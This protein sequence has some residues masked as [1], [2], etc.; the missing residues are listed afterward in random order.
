MY[1]IYIAYILESSYLTR[2]PS[3][4]HLYIFD[5]Q[6]SFRIKTTFLISEMYTFLLILLSNG[7][8]NY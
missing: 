3:F 4:D 2:P 6:I 1:I 5:S 7:M 8:D